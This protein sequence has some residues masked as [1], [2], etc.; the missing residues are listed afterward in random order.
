MRRWRINIRRRE[1][2][3]REQNEIYPHWQKI[4]TEEQHDKLRKTVRFEQEAPNTQSSSTMHV[5]LD[6]PASGEKQDRSEPVVV[7][8][9]GHVDDEMKIS[10]LDMFC[11]MDGRK[12]RHIKEVLNWFY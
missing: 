5:S 11:E 9:S 4:A 1:S 2:T 7:H 12:S 8:N 3:R 10:A 6:Y